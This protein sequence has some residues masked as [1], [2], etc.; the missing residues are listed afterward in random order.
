MLWGRNLT[1]DEYLLSAFPT[2][3]QAG[4]FSGYPNEPRTFGLTVRKR[5]N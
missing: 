5:F 2:V 3:I 4:S 1:D